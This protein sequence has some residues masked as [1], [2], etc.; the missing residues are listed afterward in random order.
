[1]AAPFTLIGRIENRTG[2]AV[3]RVSRSNPNR[4][5]DGGGWERA[6]GGKDKGCKGWEEVGAIRYER[7]WLKTIKENQHGSSSR[8]VE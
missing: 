7:K 5:D 6:K 3:Y 2:D 8:E 1:M 4:L